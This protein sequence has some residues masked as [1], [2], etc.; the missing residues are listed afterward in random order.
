MFSLTPV[1]IERMRELRRE[2]YVRRLLPRLRRSAP[3]HLPTDDLEAGSAIH[4]Q[5]AVADRLGLNSDDQ[6]EKYLYLAFSYPV[7]LDEESRKGYDDILLK[8]DL[9]GNK[10]VE[11]LH[12][13]LIAEH[14]G[15]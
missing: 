1:Q 15:T 9:D 8:P 7:L 12:H 3:E 4:Q 5:L 14:Y 11:R 13:R 2:E 6:V 10:K